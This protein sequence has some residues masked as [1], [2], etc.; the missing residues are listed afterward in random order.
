M[1]AMNKLNP[2]NSPNIKQLQEYLFEVSSKLA[3]L[4]GNKSQNHYN[5]PAQTIGLRVTQSRK[6]LKAGHSFLKLLP[7]Q[8]L[9]VYDHIWNNSRFFEEMSQAIYYYEKKSLKSEYWPFV[10]ANN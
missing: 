3:A 6:I 5:C 10:K 8:R 9:Q 2:T 4:P 1:Q 7:D